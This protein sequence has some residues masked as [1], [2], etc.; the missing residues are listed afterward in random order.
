MKTDRYSMSFTTGGLFHGE[1][2]KIAM[3]FLEFNNWDLIRGKV[4]DENLLQ[5]RTLSTSKRVCSE[6]ISRLKTLDRQ[7]IDLLVRSK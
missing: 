1:S 4:I 5:T 2:V 3:L 7:E 6:V